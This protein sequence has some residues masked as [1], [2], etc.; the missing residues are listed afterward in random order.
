VSPG[1]LLRLLVREGRGARSRLLPF[2]ASLAI[3]VAAVVLVAGLGDSLVRSLRLEARPL[4]GADVVARSARPLPPA[5][6]EVATRFPEVGRATS[7]DFLTMVAVPAADERPGRSAMAELKAVSPGWPFYGVPTLEPARPLTD[8]LDAEGVVVEP[9]LLERLGVHVGDEVRV[10]GAAFTVRGVVTAEPG[11]VP[12][13]LSTGPRLFLGLEG[14]ARSGLGDTGARITWRALYHV[15]DETRA[16]ELAAWLTAAAPDGAATVERWSDAQPSTRRSLERT[17]SWLGLVALLSLIVGGVGVA[18]STRAWLARRLDAL[19]VQRCLGLTSRDLLLVSLGQTFVFALAGS[20]L[21]AVVGTVALALAPYAL[22]GL[23]PPGAVVPWQPAAI[24][25]GVASG[26]AVALVFAA[27]PLDRAS[28]VPPLRVLRRDVEPLPEPPGRRVALAGGLGGAVFVLAWFQ[29]GDPWVAAAFGAGLLGVAAVGAGTAGAFAAAAA[30]LAHHVSP[31]WLRHGL[32][33]LGRPDAAVVPAVVSLALGVLV[34]TTTVLVERRLFAQVADEFPTQAPSAFLVDVQSDQREG[35]T[36]LLREAGGTRLEA[37]PMVVA[38][39]AAVD[40]LGIDA[41]VAAH[42]PDSRWALTR[43][44]RLTYLPA[45]PASNT[46]VQGAPFTPG[47]SGELSLEVRY[48]ESLGAKLGSVVRFDVQGVEVELTVTSLRTVSWETFDMNFFL[49]AEPG[50]L[51]DAPQ[52]TLVTVQLPVDREASV[53]DALVAGYP[54]VTLISV[55]NLLGQVRGLLE[56]VGFG[57]RAVGAFTAAAGIAIL[58]SGVA[59]D[60]V[61]Q[62]RKVALLKTLGTTRAGVVGLF[63]VE[64][65]LLGLLAGT[66]GAGGAWALSW[67]VVARWM[68]LPWRTDAPA[69]LAAVSSAVALTALVGVLAN[70]RALRARPAEVLRGE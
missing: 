34:V 48:A 65:G 25:R 29:S 20:A 17:T 30:R 41:L 27:Q 57:I 5:L 11:R 31:W 10:G 52:S 14:L 37:A 22:A 28:R 55:R 58:M 33:S 36:E 26:L 12:S 42:G 4:L 24:A 45:L 51:E 68:H 46:I 7:V 40:G 49:I 66:L 23:L 18:Q 54:N 62:A 59:A 70:M 53:Q 19:A 61:R 56:R 60:A 2:V 47:P 63:A 38:R 3:G 9:A 67:V 35:V 64:Y 15:P 16:A 43:E 50:L 6:D 21:G 1:L 8:L 13:G 69:L 39:L 32:A 44:Q